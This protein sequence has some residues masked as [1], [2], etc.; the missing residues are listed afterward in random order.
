M[1]YN[2]N[3]K[4]YFL[5]NC[6]KYPNIELVSYN[7]GKMEDMKMFENETFDYVVTS[8]VLCSVGD[9]QQSLDEVHRV[10]KKVFSSQILL[11]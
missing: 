4:N 9:V 3:F 8:H 1:E 10:L 6:K 7:I 2:E 11:F 5:D